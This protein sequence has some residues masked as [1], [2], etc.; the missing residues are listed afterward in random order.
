MTNREPAARAG[1]SRNRTMATPAP[2]ARPDLRIVRPDAAELPNNLDAEKSVLGSVLLNQQ[3]IIEV[4]AWLTPEHFYLARH[5]QI[6]A[7][8][9]GCHQQQIPPDLRM[10]SEALRKAGRLDAV[11]GI[12]YLSELIESVPTSGHIDHYGRIVTETAWR[13]H[14]IQA[15]G[16]LAA[17][18]Y[19]ETLEAGT[20]LTQLAATIDDLRGRL[21]NS[22]QAVRGKHISELWAQQF[23]P[24]TWVIPDILPEGLTLFSGKPKMGKSL[25]TIGVA[26]AVAS[27]GVALGS[28][29]VTEGDVLY[30]CLEDATRTLQ[31]RLETMLQG[32]PDIR[33][34]YE[35]SWPRLDA[36]GLGALEAWLQAHPNARLIV[37]D[38]L[39]KVQPQGDARKSQYLQ[40][41]DALDGLTQL[42]HTYNVAIIGTTHSRKADASD[43]LDLVNG[44]TGRTG[45]G[46]NVWVH[47][48]KRGDV[49]AE[50]HVELREATSSVR[51]LTFDPQL[52]LWRLGGDAAIARESRVR[53]EL[54][55]LLASDGPLWPKDAAELLGADRGQVRKQHALLRQSGL[56]RTDD[57]GRYAAT[58]AG[59][60]LV[61]TR[62][63]DQKDQKDQEDQG[64]SGSGHGSEQSILIP[65]PLD[66]LDP[67]DPSDPQDDDPFSEFCRQAGINPYGRFHLRKYLTG[68]PPSDQLHARQRCAGYGIDYTTAWQLANATSAL[69]PALDN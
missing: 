15:S 21:A 16:Q 5:G 12:L 63:A 42:A 60:E 67:S 44:T 13:R 57:R 27:G 38:T 22:G 52:G 68:T 53:R 48:R 35:T 19:D 23:A 66:P 62:L 34:W 26:A 65:D 25:V 51:A 8:M 2:H 11:G 69:P 17:L 50:L 6:Y 61:A 46:D 58:D 47:V 37:I 28:V 41:Y 18:G 1:P 36:G 33:L 64:I 24:L 3:R 43:V 10:V 31:T 56:A 54:L 9:L 30:L 45:A 32:R 55:D 59:R 29:P 14:L 20:I 4:A 39:T 7:A 40:D 49:E